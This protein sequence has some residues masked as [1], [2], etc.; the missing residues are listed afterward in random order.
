MRLLARRLF[1]KY[2]VGLSPVR[3]PV[4]SFQNIV[5]PAYRQPIPGTWGRY[6]PAEG[7]ATDAAAGP[8]KFNLRAMVR[9]QLLSASSTSILLPITS[10]LHFAQWHI[11][12]PFSFRPRGFF[13]QRTKP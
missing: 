4:L 3:F 7:T 11:R 13:T 1:S 8:W 5:T 12:K 10:Q 2:E 6:R 9:L